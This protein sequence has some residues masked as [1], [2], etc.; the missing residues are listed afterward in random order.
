MITRQAIRGFYICQIW[1]RAS[2]Q[3]LK[4]P[5]LESSSVFGVWTPSSWTHYLSWTII[6]TTP[7]VDQPSLKIVLKPSN[8]I[9]NH[10]P[11]KELNVKTFYAK[12]QRN[13]RFKWIETACFTIKWTRMPLWVLC[14]MYHKGAVNQW[15]WLILRC[16]MYHVNFMLEIIYQYLMICYIYTGL[17]RTLLI[18]EYSYFL[19]FQM[20]ICILYISPP[21]NICISSITSSS[22]IVAW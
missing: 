6:L 22:S 5:W 17:M 4:A 10:L 11:I 2:W 13:R 20:R 14:F 9:F 3:G 1:P 7:S 21:I 8:K 15:L 16:F 19:M 12:F 18:H